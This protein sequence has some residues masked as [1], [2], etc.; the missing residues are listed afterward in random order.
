MR[1][2]R[3]IPPIRSFSNVFHELSSRG[4]IQQVTRYSIRVLESVHIHS[5]KYSP[6]E[7][8]NALRSRQVIYCGVD[9]TASSLHIGNLIPLMCLLHFQLHGHTIIPLVRRAKISLMNPTVEKNRCTDRWRYRPRR[10]SFGKE[11]R[12]RACECCA[13]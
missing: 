6:T 4:F 3:H 12:T 7:L 11:D 5:W 2:I 10:R 8:E 9:P 13:D 1:S